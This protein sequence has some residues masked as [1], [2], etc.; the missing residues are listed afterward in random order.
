MCPIERGAGAL[1]KAAEAAHCGVVD[2]LQK[3]PTSFD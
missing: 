2:G 1:E 3:T